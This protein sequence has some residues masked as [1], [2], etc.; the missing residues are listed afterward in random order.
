MAFAD[1][2]VLLV[3]CKTCGAVDICTLSACQCC[4]SACQCCLSACQCC[5]SACQCCL[6]DCQY[7]YYSVRLPTRV[8]SPPANPFT[9]PACQHT[10][11]PRLPTHSHSPPANPF[12]FPACQQHHFLRLPM[13]FV[14]SPMY[15]TYVPAQHVRSAT[16]PHHHSG[17]PG[18]V[19][20]A[21]NGR[22][23]GLDPPA[24]RGTG[25]HRP[26][27]C[28][29]VGDRGLWAPEQGTHAPS[30]DGGSSKLQPRPPTRAQHV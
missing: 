11:I 20:L 4:L 19:H 16:S 8:H 30:G 1:V 23:L 22:G 3:G 17:V 10:Y 6:S 27:L 29:G 9:F 25:F 7:T 15:Y 21:D 5:L 2:V 24:Q 18:G 12:T 26:Q 13:Q 28:S 14:R